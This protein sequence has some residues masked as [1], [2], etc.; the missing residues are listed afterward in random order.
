[1]S[2]PVAFSLVG[3]FLPPA[4]KN[5]ALVAVFPPVGARYEHRPALGAAPCPSP[6][7]QGGAQAFILGQNS[8]P[9]PFAVEGVA[10][11]LD[12]YAHIAV[13]T[14]GPGSL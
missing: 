5:G 4:H 7:E 1:M 14:T 10:D 9:E 3:G 8:G 6:M 11:T 2:T 12:A 13:R